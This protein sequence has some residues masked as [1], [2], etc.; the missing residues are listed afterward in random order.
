MS[1]LV[2]FSTPSLPPSDAVCMQPGSGRRI[3]LDL[4]FNSMEGS[5][6]GVYKGFVMQ[7]HLFLWNKKN[8]LFKIQHVLESWLWVWNPSV[9]DGTLEWKKWYKN[10]RL[11]KG[12]HSSIASSSVGGAAPALRRDISWKVWVFTWFVLCRLNSACKSGFTAALSRWTQA[13]TYVCFPRSVPCSIKHLFTDVLSSCLLHPEREE[14]AGR[15]PGA[16]LLLASSTPGRGACFVGSEPSLHKY[17]FISVT[18]QL[19]ETSGWINRTQDDNME[20]AK[21]IFSSILHWLP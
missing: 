17:P 9:S 3:K 7:T 15:A 19:I 5:G 6:F 10:I 2:L 21:W 12:V 18:V 8:G 16:Q 20:G 13:K 11:R 4:I 14:L 1:Y